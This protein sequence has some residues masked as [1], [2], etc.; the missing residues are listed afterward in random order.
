MIAPELLLRT[1]IVEDYKEKSIQASIEKLIEHLEKFPGVIWNAYS[2]KYGVMIKEYPYEARN[3]F[4]IDL[5]NKTCTH[6][7]ISKGIMR[8]DKLFGEDIYKQL[9]PKIYRNN[10]FDIN[11]AIRSY[12]I[13]IT[14]IVKLK[15]EIPVTEFGLF[16]SWG[17]VSSRDEFHHPRLIKA[18]WK[19]NL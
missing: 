10:W 9:V 17:K 4:F 18:S 1:T 8:R 13:I 19:E 6:R 14:N 15:E 12:A 11:D 5:D 2:Q 3:G 7:F 16:N